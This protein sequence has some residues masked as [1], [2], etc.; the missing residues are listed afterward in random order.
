[1]RNQMQKIL[2]GDMSVNRIQCK[3]NISQKH[4]D[5]EEAINIILEI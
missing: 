1:M 5:V 2:Y 3:R 4:D